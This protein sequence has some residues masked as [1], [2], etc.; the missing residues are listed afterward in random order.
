ML[1]ITKLEELRVNNVLADWNETNTSLT[2]V[3]S[4][5]DIKTSSGYTTITYSPIGE[6]TFE[7]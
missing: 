4:A 3:V 1:I 7:L 6:T 2:V 5:S